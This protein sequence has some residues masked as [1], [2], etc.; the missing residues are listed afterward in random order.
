MKP[1]DIILPSPLAKDDVKSII[2][3]A[4]FFASGG[5][6]PLQ[7]ALN[8]LDRMPEEAFSD[9]SLTPINADELEDD[10]MA[11]VVC[12]MGS[13]DQAIKYG[14]GY[15]APVNAFKALKGY[16]E[17]KGEKVS[18]L[19]P[20][21]M[22]AVNTL[23]PYYI[24]SKWKAETGEEIRVING[25]P[26]SRSVPTIGLT[27]LHTKGNR[28]PICPAVVASDGEEE[29]ESQLFEDPNI[30][31]DTLQYAAGKFVAG[32]DKVGGLACYPA[33][34]SDLKNEEGKNQLIRGSMGLAWKTGQMIRNGEPLEN[35]QKFLQEMEP[36]I[37]IYMLIEDAMNVP[38]EEILDIGKYLLQNQ[39]TEESLYVYYENEN[40]LVWRPA[41]DE[42]LMGDLR[43]M[44]PDIISFLTSRDKTPITGG[45]VVPKGTPVSN[46]DTLLNYRYTVIGMNA[47]NNIRNPPM[48]IN[49]VKT[50]EE[51]IRQID[52]K[53]INITEY[54]PI[55]ELNP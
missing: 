8:M 28:I 39:Q 20:I 42:R 37:K 27:L 49:F 33:R 35:L 21:E 38:P 7:M 51:T 22:G 10:K 3:G 44:G 43:A 16:L 6:G 23:L 55:E 4:C 1:E 13:P 41:K 5:G 19:M 48:V 53:A 14:K 52:K 29:F 9:K 36:P 40:L 17:K 50:I 25:D 11:F 46:A 45:G 18:Y 47:H 24:A 34:G 2:L 54:Y 32:W 31:P 15:S 30:D 12:D 26:S